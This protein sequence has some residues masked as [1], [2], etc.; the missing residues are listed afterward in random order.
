M[1][2]FS[3]KVVRLAATPRR[4][5]PT[6]WLATLVAL[7]A[8]GPF[9][10]ALSGCVWRKAE[11]PPALKGEPI[12]VGVPLPLTGS[13]AAFGERKRNAY[14]MAAEEINAAGGVDGRPLVLLFRDTAGE[15]DAAASVAEELLNV[16]KVTLLA[17]EYSS[18]CALAVAGVAQRYGVPYLVDSAAADDLTE[19]GWKYVFR[20]C[21]PASLYAQGL[22]SF[23]DELVHPETMAII[24]EHSDFGSSVAQAMRAWCREN[25]VYV[26]A[27]EDY[28]PGTLDFTPLIAQVKE[29]NPDVVYMVSYLMDASLL[30]RQARVQGL[31]PKLFAGGAAGFVLPEFITNAGE[32]AESVMTAT[33]WAPSV[34][35]PGTAEFAEIYQARY[36]DY[37]TYHAAESY[38]CVYVLADALRRAAST[39]P[40]RIRVALA[41][42]DLLTAFGPIR[43]EKFEE[44]TNQSR[45]STFVLQVL[46]MKHEVV[47]PP[48]VATADY[49]YPDPAFQGSTGP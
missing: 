33:L 8:L 35:Y 25:D 6:V 1:T 24:Y 27:Y 31:N 42:T 46:K 15:P 10:A 40:E 49:A 21:P 2:E 26:V 3:T 29:A 5:V 39:D 18:A 47:W 19:Q 36:G 22:T 13:K 38:A 30:I 44:Y 43:F 28:E 45:A 32:A 12:N 48:E 16:D 7:L 11:M 4:T 34:G 20:L 9:A 41:D 17:G 23:L 37:P 14:E